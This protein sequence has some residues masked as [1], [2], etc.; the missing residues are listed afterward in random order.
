VHSALDDLERSDLDELKGILSDP[1]AIARARSSNR[2]TARRGSALR[3]D[4][5][6]K[7][8]AA[9]PSL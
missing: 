1:A 9:R 5:K 4:R 7:C 8:P 6:F 3:L 2:G